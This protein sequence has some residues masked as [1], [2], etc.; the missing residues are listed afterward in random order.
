MQYLSNKINDKSTIVGVAGLGYVGW[1]LPPAKL[2]FPS[3]E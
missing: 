1:P 2:D 3:S